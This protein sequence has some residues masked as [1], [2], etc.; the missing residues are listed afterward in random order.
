LV[1][2]L[3]SITAT[4]TGMEVRLP[5]REELQEE[6]IASALTRQLPASVTSAWTQPH[7]GLWLRPGQPH[8]HELTGAA[9]RQAIA[10]DAANT[11][12]LP[13]VLTAAVLDVALNITRSL[14]DVRALSGALASDLTARANSDGAVVELM[15]AHAHAI[16][17]AYAHAL[18]LA[19]TDA[20]TYTCAADP[21]LI[22][23]I[24]LTPA[25]ALAEV[26]A[27][28]L[29]GAIDVASADAVELADAIDL[30]LNILSLF[31]FDLAHALEVARLHATSFDRAYTLARSIP[32]AAHL[33]L[34]GVFGLAG[35]H[36]LD[37]TVPLPGFLGLPLRWVADGPLAGTLLQV[38]AA[39]SPSS[40]SARPLSSDPYLAFALALC[41]R[42]GISETTPL[43]A[44]LG[45]P[46]TDK[47]RELK[48]AGPPSD[49]SQATGLSRLTDA[50]APMSSTHRPPSPPEAAALRAVALALADGA[51]GP[52][53]DAAAVLRSV[54]ATVTLVENREKGESRVGESVILGLA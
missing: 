8:P 38:L 34:A 54:A 44:A 19:R 31:D 18:D 9:I 14:D 2:W 10:V 52:G 35:A 22:R 37:P 30:D 24:G 46:L 16:V 15:H 1:A 49:W 5:R 12:M 40:A 13:Q 25:R 29:A 42:A 21:G 36:T 32:R 53:T 45:C 20:V 26:I 7:P 4:A 23:A 11:S 39:S 48:A 41:T 51:T 3:N 50:C 47:L 28:D 43:R 17:L 6:A 33:D 27:R